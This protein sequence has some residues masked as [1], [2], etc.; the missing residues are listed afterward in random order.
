[1]PSNP[2]PETRCDDAGGW[3]RLRIP[4]LIAPGTL[5]VVRGGEIEGDVLDD[6]RVQTDDVPDTFV[7]EDYEAIEP[8]TTVAIRPRS[9]HV[10]CKPAAAVERDRERACAARDRRRQRRDERTRAERAAFWQQYDLPIAA[11]TAQ[12]NRLGELRRGSTGTGATS[13]TVRHLRVLEPVDE[14][15][16]ERDAPRFLCR[17][18]G[19][20]ADPGMGLGSEEPAACDETTPVI[21]CQTCL[22]RMDRWRV[23]DTEAAAADVAD[24]GIQRGED[25]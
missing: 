4:G 6:G 14:P 9:G 10:Y 12:N 24:G 7:L 1:M 13:S 25:G 16:L 8:G 21:T 17:G 19:K 23:T 18:E 15:R 20:H 3:Q 2:D 22:D 5:D 11:E